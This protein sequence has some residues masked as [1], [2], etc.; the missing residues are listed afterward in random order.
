[1]RVAVGLEE[2]KQSAVGGEFGGEG[3]AAGLEGFEAL[4]AGGVAAVSED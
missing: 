2:G 4:E 1:M 3:G